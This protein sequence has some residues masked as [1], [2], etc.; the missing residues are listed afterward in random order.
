MYECVA[1]LLDF[2]WWRFP[3]FRPHTARYGRQMFS[4]R[5]EPVYEFGMSVATREPCPRVVIC[6]LDDKIT[7]Q[8]ECS[9]DSPFSSGTKPL[10]AGFQALG[11]SECPSV[12]NH[13]D[14]LLIK[15]D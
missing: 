14:L 11:T 3:T 4:E 5:G 8:L 6:E 12:F 1:Q 9:G 15:V 7:G 2:A 10:T 13:R